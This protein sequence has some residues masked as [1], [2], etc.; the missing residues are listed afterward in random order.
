MEFV[1]IVLLA[2][3]AACAYGI[4]HDQITVRICLEYF[5]VGHAPLV[6]TTSPTLLGIAFGIAATWWFG[7]ILGLILA[8]VSRLG[9]RPKVRAV[10]LLPVV[11]ILLTSMALAAL[12]VGTLGYVLASAGT[13]YLTEPL[14]SHVPAEQHVR[15]LADAFAH[16]ASYATAAIGGLIICWFIW[17]RRGTTSFRTQPA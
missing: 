8:T 11:A 15:F 3:A 12:L 1:K 13:I 7:A 5:T 17:R 10:Q 14:A 2:M 9:P 6:P 4:V 16:N